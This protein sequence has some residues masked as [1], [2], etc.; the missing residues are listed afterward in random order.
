MVTFSSTPAQSRA[1]SLTALALTTLRE[2]ILVGEHAPGAPLR[3]E[4]LQRQHGLSSSPL[5]E[6]LN[7]LVAE[8]LVTQDSNKGFRV[9][10]ISAHAF[11]EL[12]ELRLLIE[13]EALRLS[14]LHGDD[15]WEGRVVAAEHHLRGAEADL[16]PIGTT[17]DKDWSMAHRNFHME[18][19][20]AA[21][22]A[23]LRRQCLALFGEGERYRRL[24]S[25]YRK[26]ARD[27]ANEHAELVAAGLSSDAERVSALLREHILTT[28]NNMMAI[29][30]DDILRPPTPL[31]AVLSTGRGVIAP[32]P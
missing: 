6:A 20:S 4:A 30:S 17:L 23:R 12:T 19:L 16:D 18:L 7:R 13:P 11:E 2:A 32:T 21:P 15:A 31:Q 1:P 9:S 8:G 5:R 26:R 28:A 22:S 29:L 27:K 24:T 14:V 10:E 25:R 3:L